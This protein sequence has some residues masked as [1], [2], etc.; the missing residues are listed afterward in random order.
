MRYGIRLKINTAKID[1]QLLFRGE[2]G[3]YLDATI[4]MDP[5]VEGQYGDH[6]MVTQDVSREARE[7]GERGPIIGNVKVF[8]TAESDGGGRGGAAAS[9][10]KTHASN[11]QKPEDFDDDIPF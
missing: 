7:A 5:D 8:H 10:A 9:H 1:K 11:T 6:G 4:W 3:T 2:K